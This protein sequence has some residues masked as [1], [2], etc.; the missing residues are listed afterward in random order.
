MTNMA[1]KKDNKTA[2]GQPA[3][4]KKR[5]QYDP[6]ILGPLTDII[7]SHRNEIRQ[8]CSEYT[9]IEE[10]PNNYWHR[11]DTIVLDVLKAAADNG[12]RT[13]HMRL[14]CTKRQNPYNIS[15]RVRE[16][17]SRKFIVGWIDSM[18][19]EMRSDD[20]WN[21]H[22]CYQV[23]THLAIMLNENSKG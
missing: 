20:D 2:A 23:F 5:G 1:K 6:F 17:Q 8:M 18:D 22:C 7:Y 12:W 16:Q 14:A 21:S 19:D 4:K 9:G 11:L 15:C 13:H 10:M 3:E